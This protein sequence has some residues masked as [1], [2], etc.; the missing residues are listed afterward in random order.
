MAG[1]GLV[2]ST[3]TIKYDALGQ[4]MRVKST[5]FIGNHTLTIDQLMLFKQVSWNYHKMVGSSICVS[6]GP[7]VEL[8]KKSGWAAV[9]LNCRICYLK[10]HKKWVEFFF[11]QMSL[12]CLKFDPQTQL[13]TLYLSSIFF[14][15]MYSALQGSTFKI[16]IPLILSLCPVWMTCKLVIW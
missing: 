9:F 16:T 7:V 15:N 10:F 3:G 5:R 4:R 11:I 13:L 8:I 6:R 14:K 1:N 2:S 12:F